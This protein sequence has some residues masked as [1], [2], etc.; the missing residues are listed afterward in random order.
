LDGGTRTASELPV[1]LLRDLKD[2]M[3]IDQS[4]AAAMKLAQQ[5]CHDI[6][7]INC[8]GPPRMATNEES[9][10]MMGWLASHLSSN[11]GPPALPGW[12]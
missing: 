10:G 1:T 11:G 4:P 6:D 9:L 12:Q 3:D 8:I 7:K 5:P 2:N